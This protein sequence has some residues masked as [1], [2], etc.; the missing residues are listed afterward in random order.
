MQL[1]AWISSQVSAVR[2]GLGQLVPLA[3]L[4]L[5]TAEELERLVCGEADWDV[6]DLRKHAVVSC[7]AGRAAHLWKALGELSREERQLFVRFA[8]GRSRLPLGG[9][10][11]FRLN[12]HNVD[13]PDAHLPTAGTCFFQVTIPKYTNYASLKAK[14]LY[15][16]YNCRDMDLC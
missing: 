15:A 13:D 14:L 9:S 10:Y 8:W 11:R 5:F 16:I 12:E 2:R 1:H 6:T 3:V 7:S 4:Q